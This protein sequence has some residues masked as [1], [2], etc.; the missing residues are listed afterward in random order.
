MTYYFKIVHTMKV[1]IL[2]KRN[3][4]GNAKKYITMMCGSDKGG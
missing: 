2:S 4:I 3:I 1:E